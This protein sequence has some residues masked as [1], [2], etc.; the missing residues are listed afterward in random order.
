MAFGILFAQAPRPD[1]VADPTILISI[2]ALLSIALCIGITKRSVIGQVSV[3]LVATQLALAV[4]G[5]VSILPH[6]HSS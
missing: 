4:F 2:C 6:L 5:T 3:I 1:H